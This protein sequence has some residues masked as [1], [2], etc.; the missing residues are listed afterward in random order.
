[1]ATHKI[2]IGEE[3]EALLPVLALHLRNEEYQ[4][5]C[6]RDG[7][8]LVET[9]RKERPDLIL[10]SLTLNAGEGSAYEVFSNFPDLA[11]IPVIYLVPDW[12]GPRRRKMPHLPDHASIRKPVA[13]GELIDKVA[14]MLIDFAVAGPADEQAA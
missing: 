10:L 3:D 14:A 12:S 13:T 6:A 5:L 8:E 9:A 11:S 2:L 4:V 7:G 1:M